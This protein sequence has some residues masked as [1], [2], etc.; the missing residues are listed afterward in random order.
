MNVWCY[1]WKSSATCHHKKFKNIV[2][3]SRVWQICF[4]N[5]KQSGQIKQRLEI[6]ITVYWKYLVQCSE[7]NGFTVAF[8]PKMIKMVPTHYK[9]TLG[10]IINC[11]IG[12]NIHKDQDENC[13]LDKKKAYWCPPPGD[14]PF[15][16]LYRKAPPKSGTFFRLQVKQRVGISLVEVYRWKICH[17]HV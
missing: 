15:H 17:F 5:W 6:I 7:R 10:A 1:L 9:K 16:G 3:S 11:E 14:I 2:Y 4:N 8:W 12:W 13:P